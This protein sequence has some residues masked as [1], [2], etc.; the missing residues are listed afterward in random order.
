MSTLKIFKHSNRNEWVSFCRKQE[1]YLDIYYESDFLY[2]DA[3]LQKGE[4]EIFTYQRDAFVFVYPY[5]KL[6]IPIQGYEGYFDISSPYGYAGPYVNTS[7]TIFLDEA[8]EA[9]LDYFNQLGIVTEF[10]RYHYQYND[11]GV[12]FK[13]NIHNIPNRAIVVLNLSSGA[14]YIWEKEFSKKCRNLHRKT[15]KE[16]FEFK[17]CNEEIDIETFWNMYIQTMDNAQA[18]V[19]YYFEKGYIEE[20]MRILDSRIK[21][22]NV[23]RE[24]VTYATALFYLNNGVVTYYLSARNFNYPKVNANSYLLSKMILWASSQDYVI[25]NLG[26]GTDNNPR[27][28]LLAFKKNFSTFVPTFYIGKRIHRQDIYDKIIKI[29]IKEHGESAYENRKQLLQFYR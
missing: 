19:F 27:N 17:F 15:E 18:E 25:F 6:I 23:V 12:F 9:L 16:G 24:G 5:I 20:T 10:I 26:G 22:C 4:Y 2:L 14:D 13:I 11:G 1:L 7:D 29:Y 8:E 21:L 28:S 3:I